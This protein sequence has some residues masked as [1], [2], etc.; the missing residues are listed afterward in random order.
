MWTYERKLQYPVNITRPNAQMAKVMSQFV[1]IVKGDKLFWHLPAA[2]GAAIS[3]STPQKGCFAIGEV[4]IA[5][6][7]ELRMDTCDGIRW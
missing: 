2:G 3:L 5:A 7:K 1:Q 4:G 6:G